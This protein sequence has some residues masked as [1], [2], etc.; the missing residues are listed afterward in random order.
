MVVATDGGKYDSRSQR[1]PIQIH[2][3]DINNNKPIFDKYPFSAQVGALIQPGQQLMQV[4]ANDADQGTNGEI[5]YS[6]IDS[7][8]GKFRINP[9]TGVVSASQSLASENGRLIH[10][11]VLARDKGNPPQ[12]ASGLI[13]LRIGEVPQGLPVLRFQRDVYNV[14]LVENTPVGFSVLSLNAV[15]SDGRRQKIMY[16]FGSGNEDG[17]FSIDAT[18]GEIRVRNS[19]KLDYERYGSKNSINHSNNQGIRLI[20]VARTDGIPLIYGYCSIFLYLTDENDNAPRFTQQQYNSAVWEGNNKGTYVMQVNAFDADQGANSR[21]LYHIVDGNH[22]NAF[23]IEP[24]FSGI[25]KTNIVLDREIRDT[26]RLKVIA[27]DEG[28]PQMTGTTFILVNI[29]DKNDNHPTFPPH[30]IISISEGKNDKNLI[31][32]LNKLNNLYFFT[33]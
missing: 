27:T 25:V 5:V 1:V 12:T 17:T 30:S 6:L 31:K 22:D 9:N 29:I 28:V 21:V 32:C 7:S 13:E 4:S 2:I 15:R 33:F 14:T 18:N 11:E 8:N 20:A 19:D 26:Y 24:A 3:D 16:S 10:L 23:I